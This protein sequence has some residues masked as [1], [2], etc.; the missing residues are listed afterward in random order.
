MGSNLIGFGLVAATGTLTF[1]SMVAYY[2]SENMG[3]NGWV[4]PGALAGM[5][6]TT[7]TLII[8][9]KI[10]A[11]RA[12]RREMIRAH[13]EWQR[14]L[15]QF[16]LR[17][18][19]ALEIL[20][21]PVASM[22]MWTNPQIGIGFPPNSHTGFPGLA[23]MLLPGQDPGHKPDPG[24]RESAVGVRLRVQLPQG[25]SA[26]LVRSRLSNLASSLDVPRVSVVGVDG[27]V[28][29]LE[30]RVRNPLEDSRMFQGPEHPVPLKALRVGVREDGEWYRIKIQ[31]NHIFLAGL[32][33][34]G[35][36]GVL[37]S[38]IGALAPDIK[39][40]RVELHVID[41]KMGV[42]MS[43]G[44]RLFATFTW[45]AL[46]A[47]DT[48]EMLVRKMRSRGDARR[49][50]SMRTGE[51]GRDHEP[52]PG[53][54]LLV[55]L[56]DEILDLLKISGDERIKRNLIAAD[57]TESDEESEITIAK[58]AGRLLLLLLSQGRALGISIITAT[59]NAAKAVFE[60][61]RDMYPMLVGLRLAGEEQVRMV[62][63]VGAAARG[64]EATEIPVDQPGTAFIDSPEA[65]GEALRVRFFRVSDTDIIKLVEI[66]G[67]PVDELPALPTPAPAAI[68][69]KPAVD[70][71]G[72]VVALHPDSEGQEKPLAEQAAGAP[73]CRYCGREL[74]PRQGG[75]RPAQFCP[76]TN[77]RQEYHRKVKQMKGKRA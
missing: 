45:T 33:G 29:K 20:T 37:W 23:P 77:H 19:R 65:G 16:P 58:Y 25:P 30:L 10:S 49:E 50:R 54:P 15:A 70:A 12:Q 32:T 43:A 36:S 42:E 3:Y 69:A 68:E 22:L 8:G 7:V 73:R 61:L 2:T 18:Q 63:G 75:G 34:S 5:A 11:N 17:T 71:G 47:L 44:Y 62:Y 55:L 40:G 56:I 1:G 67:R 24:Y 52:T 21:D 60:L 39:S 53:D 64:I 26:D 13:E 74:P 48:L 57:G 72:N 51:P 59:Q 6:G 76:N 28:V 14:E 35:K 31:G 9:A 27:Q 41:L 38:V 66:F 46:A 4:G